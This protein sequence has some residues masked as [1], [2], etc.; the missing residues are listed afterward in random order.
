MD[1]RDFETHYLVQQGLTHLRNPFIKGMAEKNSY[2]I[3]SVLSPIG[4]AF[5]IVPLIN[6]ITRVGTMEEKTLLFESMLEYKALDLILST[7][8]GCAGQ[9]ETRL[10]QSLR[11]CTNVKNR[12]TRNQDAAVEQ[13]KKV[14]EKENLLDHKLLLIR[15]REAAFDR[16]ITGLIA[17]KI[18]AEYQRPVALLIAT[19]T[20]DGLTWSGSARGYGKS[21]DLTD[22]RKFCEDSN[23]VVYAQGHA[24]AFGLSIADEKFDEFV[25]YSDAVLQEAKFSPSY[26]VDFIYNSSSLSSKDILTLGD[27]KTL[28]GQNMDEPLLAVEHIQVTKDMVTLMSRDKNP[29]LKIQLS[30]GV[31]C[32]K[33]KSNEEE[34][35]AFQV[36]DSGCVTI[37]LVAR[38]EVNKYF[39][40]VTPQLIVVDYE[41]VNKQQYYF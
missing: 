18:M 37:N 28:W 32:I 15:L 26:K 21:N 16:G 12:Q 33:F 31:A 24:Q 20:E 6:A 5:Y 19:D 4:V 22:F 30:N 11:T 3:G 38:P 2:S 10:A 35:E 1:I 25:Q 40:S 29:T 27:M 23:M 17:N 39:N 9:Q 13:V 8:R 34:F 14:I 41:I 36:S 7:K